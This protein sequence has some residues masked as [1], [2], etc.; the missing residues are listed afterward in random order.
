MDKNIWIMSSYAHFAMPTCRQTTMQMYRVCKCVEED[1]RQQWS[2]ASV[3]KQQQ[4]S[5]TPLLS[6]VSRIAFMLQ[7]SAIKLQSQYIRIVACL[8]VGA[9]THYSCF[10]SH[11][12]HLSLRLSPFQSKLLPCAH[13]R[14]RVKH[15]VL[16]VCI[17]CTCMWLKGG[18]SQLL[19]EVK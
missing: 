11:E 16:S 4:S 17:M 7:Q 6:P 10:C 15:L 12:K 18:V 9:T 2:S 13:I 1:W 5:S 14:N 8:Q 19:I 3:K